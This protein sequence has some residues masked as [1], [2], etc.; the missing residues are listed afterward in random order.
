MLDPMYHYFFLTRIYKI[1]VKYI[2]K[3]NIYMLNINIYVI[4]INIYD[5]ILSHKKLSKFFKNL[6]L[7]RSH[8]LEIVKYIQ[9]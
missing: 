4:Y 1:Y 5:N 3:I 6:K 8:S 7:K 9:I 2:Y